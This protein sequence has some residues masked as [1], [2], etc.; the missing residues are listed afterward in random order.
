MNA[1]NIF[2]PI[3]MMLACLLMGCAQ[4]TST[5]TASYIDPA[6]ENV[7]F[8]TLIVAVDSD[9]L[10]EREAIEYA[11]ADALQD[12]GVGARP[13]MVVVIPTRGRVGDPSWVR[14]M[15]KS[16][17]DGIL[18]IRPIARAVDRECYQS[19]RYGAGVGIGRGHM[20]HTYYDGGFGMGFHE[21]DCYNEPRAMYEATI[22]V[23][24]EYQS[25]W[26][27]EFRSAG[28]GGMDFNDVGQHFARQ[29]VKRLI[30]DG[31]I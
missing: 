4:T 10:S 28:A 27:G 1:Q 6:Y 16:G 19:P 21:R 12:A 7:G 2:I 17:A 9:S 22:Y 20:D 11:A 23:L 8:D 18:E 14:A 29:L 26:T 25:A 5:R 31:V 3:F 13:A 30:N 24:P 15:K